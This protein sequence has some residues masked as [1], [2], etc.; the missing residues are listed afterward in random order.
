MKMG[1]KDV[2]THFPK[3]H[4]SSTVR[5]FLKEVLALMVNLTELDD[6]VKIYINLSTI[7]NSKYLTNDVTDAINF[8][9]SL[10][11]QKTKNEKKATVDLTYEEQEE[12]KKMMLCIGNQNF[13]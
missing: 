1:A 4:S 2:D 8:I 5:T 11:E 6:M 7:L 13:I 3:D 10:V 9:S 12:N